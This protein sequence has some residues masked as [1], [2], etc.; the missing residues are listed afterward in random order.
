MPTLD[1]KLNT[2]FKQLRY[3]CVIL[4]IPR[5]KGTPTKTESPSLSF[6]TILSRKMFPSLQTTILNFGT[7]FRLLIAFKAW[8]IV[9]GPYHS[10]GY[11]PSFSPSWQILWMPNGAEGVSRKRSTCLNPL[12]LRRASCSSICPVRTMQPQPASLWMLVPQSFLKFLR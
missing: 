6:L 4:S 12:C 8:N 10:P 5:R 11:L 3:S 1:S 7:G 9:C 2:C